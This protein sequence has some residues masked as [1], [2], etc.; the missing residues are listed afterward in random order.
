[1]ETDLAERLAKRAGVLAD[2][3]IE[4]LRL[5]ATQSDDPKS[6][7]MRDE[8]RNMSRGDLVTLILGFEFLEE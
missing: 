3:S 2:K 7:D 6:A 1:M 4:E 8:F 5:I